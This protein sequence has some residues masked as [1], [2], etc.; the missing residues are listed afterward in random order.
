MHFFSTLDL[1]WVYVM[2]YTIYFETMM[3]FIFF[4]FTYKLCIR[5]IKKKP[6]FQEST[7][8]FYFFSKNLFLFSIR[9]KSIVTWII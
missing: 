6:L 1:M 2:F 3:L 7:M 5:V 8:I 9:L 4:E